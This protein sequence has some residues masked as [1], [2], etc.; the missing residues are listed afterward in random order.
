MSESTNERERRVDEAIAWY[1]RQAEAGS[2]PD[3]NAFLMLYPD[4]REDLQ[5]F[6]ADKAAFHRMAGPGDPDAT[7]T[8]DTGATPQ[9][10]ALLGR[11]RYFGDYELIAEIA[12]GGMGVVYRARQV[13]LNRV[14]ALKMILSGQLASDA[15][16]K[17]FRQE[18][19]SAAN[20]DHPNILPI[21]EVGEHD[22]RQ[23]FSMKLVE[24][25]S[26]AQSPR[27]NV[28]GLVVLLIKVARAVHFAHQRNLL[29][30]DLK[31]ANVL[32]DADGTPYVTDFGL[33]KKVEGDAGLTQS[34]A[35][36]GTPSYMAPEQARAAK[37]LT[38][39]IDVYSLG[40]ILYEMLTGQ[41]PF[42]GTGVMDTVLQVLNKEA[43][44]PRKLNPRIDRDLSVIA[45]K[46]LSKE[47]AKRYE[48][49]AALADDLERWQR[50]EPIV[51]RPVSSRERFV[52]WVRRNPLPAA[53]TAII[54]LLLISGLTAVT[55]LYFRSEHFRQ[56]AES[57]RDQARGR[58]ARQYV[59][60]A[61][62]FAEQ[63]N[64][65]LGLPWLVE[66]IKTT[67][68]TPQGELHRLHLRSLLSTTP[69]L[70]HYMPTATCAALHPDGKHVA[71]G[72]KNGVE[73]LP[74][75]SDRSTV[76]RMELSVPT[77]TL[78]FSPNG[79]RLLIAGG[80]GG[81]G[82][83]PW[84]VTSVRVFDAEF[85][86]ALTPEKK[87]GR[88]KDG[89]T[90]V[91]FSD[92]GSVIVALWQGHVNRHVVNMEVYLYDA[93]TLQP[94]GKPFIWGHPEGLDYV[95]IDY[96]NLRA[97]T[98]C[99]NVESNS[100]DFT[101]KTQVWDLRTSVALFEPIP[102]TLGTPTGPPSPDGS[103][104]AMQLEKVV[105]LHSMSTGKPTG[106]PLQ[107]PDLVLSVAWRPDGKVIA[108]F[109]K[110][111]IMRT[112]DAA[113][114]KLIPKDFTPCDTDGVRALDYSPDGHTLY[115]NGQ[116]GLAA[117]DADSGQSMLSVDYD[118]ANHTIVFSPDGV[119]VV[120]G[121]YEGI[122]IWKRAGERAMPTLPHGGPVA[123]SFTAN[124]RYLLTTGN[125]IR[126]WDLAVPRPAARPVL[127]PS[128][129]Q[130]GPAIINA[131]NDRVA[132]LD[133][134]GQVHI[135]DTRTGAAIG[136]S[137]RP[138]GEWRAAQLSPDGKV[139]ATIGWAEGH[140]GAPTAAEVAG[141]MC[142]RGG[143]I[144]KSPRDVGV[145]D[146]ATGKAI[147]APLRNRSVGRVL[148]SPDS[149][150][151]FVTDQIADY[152]GRKELGDGSEDFSELSRWDLET[153]E[154]A[155]PV[156]R[157]PGSLE[158]V[159][160]N[161]AGDKFLA[162]VPAG[163]KTHDGMPTVAAQIWDARVLAPAGGFIGPANSVVVQA[164]FSSDFARV[165]TVSTDGDAHVWDPA[166]GALVA[167]PFHH[168]SSRVGQ[169]P[170][171]SMASFSP[172]GKR[173]ATGTG[174]DYGSVGEARVW[175][176]AT[177]RP[178][179]P[180]LKAERWMRSAVFSPDGRLLVTI[181]SST[182]TWDLR[183]WE[184]DTG[185]P[186]TPPLALPLRLSGGNN[187][188]VRDV[189]DQPRFTPDGRRILV[190]S[191]AGLYAIDLVPERR[192]ADE[193]E[194]L[195]KILSGH[196]VDS[197]GGFQPLAESI[198]VEAAERWR[199]LNPSPRTGP[200]PAYT[201]FLARRALAHSAWAAAT[202]LLGD[203]LRDHPEATWAHAERAAAFEK[204]QLLEPARAAWDQVIRLSDGPTARS[205]RGNVLARLGRFADA[206]VDFAAAWHAV[207]EPEEGARLALSQWA[208]GDKE[209]Y[210]KTCEQLRDRR[211]DFGRHNDGLNLAVLGCGLDPANGEIVRP[212]IPLLQGITSVES[213]VDL[214]R[215]LALAYV[216]IGDHAKAME[217]QDKIVWSNDHYSR[218]WQM[219]VMEL[220]KS[221]GP[222][223]S[224]GFRRTVLVKIIDDWYARES[225][226]LDWTERVIVPELRNQ[227]R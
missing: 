206:A 45:L 93:N 82:M 144:W 21:Y 3:S 55:R 33:A 221:G 165:L 223:G 91:R 46:C 133:A 128:A 181:G 174:T 106:Q 8:Q 121:N 74:F 73:I 68:G 100:F 219:L 37:Q 226:A 225:A 84:M 124:G 211:D 122:A 16:V 30:R 110:D 147:V 118:A 197:A 98:P 9:A 155:A 192:P 99:R 47:P 95:Q 170:S 175:D 196:E 160:M 80:V 145:W 43:D 88:E 111:G 39:G 31:P 25:G 199:T 17:R 19:E 96:K 69:A 139:V 149:K 188:A 23:Y 14:V 79:K 52:K 38:T 215:S 32:L 216:R 86:K 146:A 217:V 24:G 187:T 113:T 207:H 57:Q 51:A 90:S 164:S 222:L 27:T 13:S 65:L 5:S 150:A 72:K 140:S 227:A 200:A 152:T 212:F 29:H 15:D 127:P 81:A 123:P 208:A 205:A 189:S 63:K 180:V 116:R 202:R 78:V 67:D 66:A 153:G 183:V 70:V 177:G 224:V 210:R 107:H 62:A 182:E 18:A 169:K 125:G 148:F 204:Q 167:G 126:L 11:V 141:R 117:R 36:V 154:L 163:G 54:L 142:A 34:G 61:G 220:P 87:V 105:R 151:I 114:G 176:L 94:I 186:V 22:G 92:D 190:P 56:D 129:V 60:K 195:A 179:T 132:T 184:A 85:G 193:L 198:A 76:A 185:M 137:F 2:P 130:V 173:I 77:T 161:G 209:G 171:I 168:T 6:L 41:P 178:V 136:A 4:L 64:P 120:T 26:L 172:D 135:H 42:R 203:Y 20:L 35:L 49:A 218:H 28:R 194:P 138:P 191:E 58:L 48:S 112:W 83:G 40:A 115:V 201:E 108:T 10:A 103:T 1:Y 75:D 12:R 53:F 44:D 158:I 101:A 89:A 7:V 143:Y 102:S 97:L 50:G 159:S 119:H 162:I 214:L 104:F 71:I 59:E 131:A 156:V 134:D 213:H 109:C 166:T 157:Q